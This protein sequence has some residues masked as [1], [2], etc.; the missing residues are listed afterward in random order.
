MKAP[1]FAGPRTADTPQQYLHRARM[2]RDAA[3]PLPDYKNGEQFWP[4]FALLTHAIE[5]ALKAFVRHSAA[6]GNPIAKEPKQHDL[7][8]W[9]KLAL[10]CG[11]QDDPTIGQ[12]IEILNELHSTHYSRYPQH[13]AAPIP[14]GD[15]ILDS[16][17]S[18]LI[19]TFTPTINPR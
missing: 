6:N 4:R 3:I 1:I 2:F 14:A 19:D 13:R 17:V 12:N 5:L 9:Y 16:T 18:H 7:S 10:Q 8:G 11:L 15:T